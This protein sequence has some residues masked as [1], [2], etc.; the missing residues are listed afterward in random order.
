MT[1][2]KQENGKWLCQIDRKGLKRVRKSFGTQ[3]EAQ[4]FEREYLW[5]LKQ[6]AAR[7]DDP[8]TLLEL[9]SIWYK[10][11]G[12]NLADPEKFRRQLET[13]A[14]DL[15]NPIGHMLTAEMLVQYRYRR[16]QG[17]NAVSQ[18]TWNN[19]QGLLSSMYNR[20]IRL[21]I[22]AYD[23]PLNGVDKMKPQ[24]RSMSYLSKRQIDDLLD[25][26]ERHCRNKNTWW[27]TNICL[28][29]GARWGEAMQLRRKQLHNGRITFEKT[30]SKKVRTIPL[31][32]D[33]YKR[34]M[35]FALD[36]EPEHRLFENCIKSFEYAVRKSGIY[37]PKGQ[38][39]HILRHS[40]AAHF[41]MNDGNI[42]TLKEILGHS[43]IKMTLRYAHLSPR[44]LA[45]AVTRNPLS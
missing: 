18:K 37:L 31:D 34:L 38:L 43:D 15:G 32:P 17:P 16:T 30:K 14:T 26:I 40:F 19:I 21:Q 20:L 4:I 8:R 45:D 29:T 33:F 6:Q 36:K 12:I 24:E 3:K 25:Y 42:L 41:M 9:V 5:G 2:K 10:Y 28:R 7:I 23:N 11:H 35:E 27:V 39:S 22:I 1:V 44:H 13:V